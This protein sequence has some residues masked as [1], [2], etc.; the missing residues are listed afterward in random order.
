MLQR[1]KLALQGEN[2]EI[3]R[4]RMVQQYPV[5]MIDEFQD[6]SPDQYGIFDAL[7]KIGENRR[8]LGLFLIG[9]PK[10]SIYGFRGAD[11]HSYL[12]ARKATEGRHYLLGTNFRSTHDLVQAVNTVFQYAEG[13]G[14]HAGFMRGAFKFRQSDGSNPVPFEAVNANGRSERLVQGYKKER[15]SASAGAGASASADVLKLLIQNQIQM[16]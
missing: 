2:G 9:D 14:D 3:L 16:S 11:I 1:L 10:Q 13:I 5:A 7:Y 15:T 12:A 6:T 4:E 8:D